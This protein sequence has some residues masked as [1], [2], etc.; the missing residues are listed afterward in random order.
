MQGRRWRITQSVHRLSDESI[1]VQPPL[2][3]PLIGRKLRITDHVRPIV[4][5]RVG[6][7]RGIQDVE[8]F[9]RLD[10][11]NRIDLP[12][13][14]DAVRNSRQ[15][16]APWQRVVHLAAPHVPHVPRGRLAFLYEP[17]PGHEVG[18]FGV[19]QPISKC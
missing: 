12:A 10:A 2:H 4:E 7:C 9:A 18:P 16:L 14:Q 13:G 1:R 3:R 8:R 19:R 17:V 15:R 5:A 6:P 11:R